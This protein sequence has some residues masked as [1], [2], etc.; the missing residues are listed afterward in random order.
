MRGPARIRRPG[1]ARLAAALGLA[2]LTPPLLAWTARPLLAQEEEDLTAALKSMRAAFNRARE[3][4]ENLDFTGAARELS[5]IIEPRKAAKAADLSVEEMNLLCAAYDM[6][7]RALFNLGNVKSAE[8]DFAA[9][10]KLNPG[11][12]IDRQTLSPKVVDLFDRVRGKIAGLLILHLDPPRARLLVDG[13]PVERQG[14]GTI[15]VLSGNHMLR[16]EADGYDPFEEM[17]AVVA[18]AETR[19]TITLRPNRRT[20]QFVT[21]PPG[22]S[23][24][25]DGGP[26]VL[27]AGPATPESEALAQQG[28]FD[29]K[30]ASAPL[31]IP[32]VTAG[33]HK[34]TFEKSCYQSRALAIKVSLDL[35]QN[36]PMKFTPVVL[37]DAK[38]ELRLTSTPSGADVF[39]DGEK[40]GTTPLVLPGQCGGERDLAV[41]KPDVGSWS[42]RIRLSAGEVNTLDVKLRP[43]LAYVGTF[44]LDEWG[45]AVWSDEDKPLLD[46]LAKGLKTLN[47][48]RTPATLQALR[49]SIIKWMITEPE[50]VRAGT[51]LPP[52]ILEE[53]ASSARADLVL[54]GLTLGGD[55]E[56]SWTL[57]L[58][59]VQ[60]PAP[61]VVRLRLDQPEGV[62]E[63]VKRLD[64]A[65]PSRGPWWGMGLVDSLLDGQGDPDGPL[66]VRVLPGGPASKAGLR[67][68]D[69]I[70]A[71]GNRKTPGVRDVNQAIA[72]EMSR[73]GGLKPTLV[74]AVEDASGPR[75]VRLTPD[76]GPI[77]T[78]LS[79]PSL[80]Y[81]RALAEFRLRSRAATEDGDRG[82]S[83]LN[84]G[85]AY[86]HF[87]VYDKAESEGF[88]RAGLPTVTGVSQGTVLYYR[89][90]CA[91][92]RGNPAAARSAFE[93]A[94]A[95]AGSTLDSGD[96]PSAA[97]AASRMLKAID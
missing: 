75:T 28:G 53:A 56:K 80:L 27:S 73:P 48:V 61:D 8:G 23:V 25:V 6:R 16:A 44:R 14:V 51:L 66:V 95:Q 59:S 17:I 47:V 40:K 36:A 77:V 18:G 24:S 42:E 74:L 39:V 65:P 7:A 35:E 70:H 67:E 37:Q 31:L 62:R 92:R 71:V 21:V 97:S 76:E 82:A 69:R 85:V 20:L 22:V 87:R 86:M 1:A 64:T 57:A 46:E 13:D 15:A 5:T 50:E 19:K 93:Q 83:L 72:A 3:R 52:A 58:Y 81:N 33:D 96:G 84:L 34:V 55:N 41:I 91:L 43:T 78:P 89:G 12:A 45:R 32:M 60:H 9:L 88:A 29:P 68:G 4:I 54:A 38:S 11:Y 10:L 90:L 49:D 79:D 26:A 2:L 30:N 63:F 94:R